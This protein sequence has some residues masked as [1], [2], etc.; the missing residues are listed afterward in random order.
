VE[1]L[2]RDVVPVESAGVGVL[3]RILAYL[4]MMLPPVAVPLALV[5]WLPVFRTAT[6]RVYLLG[7]GWL[8]LASVFSGLGA[9]GIFLWH[10]IP[11]LAGASR[12]F[13]PVEFISPAWGLWL[14]LGS[15]LVIWVS[16][17]V[18]WRLLPS[19]LIGAPEPGAT[20]VYSRHGVV[21]TLVTGGVAL[22]TAGFLLL[23]WAQTQCSALVISLTHTASG[24]C[25]TLDGY[26]ALSYAFANAQPFG[27]FLDPNTISPAHVLAQPW[28]IVL[29]CGALAI[30][31]LWWQPRTIATHVCSA[32]WLAGAIILT[33][34]G[35]YGV[36]NIF[37][38]A[39]TLIYGASAGWGTGAGVVVALVGIALTAFG[40]A[41]LAWRQARPADVRL[42]ASV[43]GDV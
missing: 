41:L 28:E 11:T 22:W 39:P 1:L 21:E 2:L 23:P 43:T 17:I 37:D 4:L 19:R 5:L 25:S 18:A 7:F 12:P 30:V 9:A 14:S 20:R 26:D 24:N 6:R 31:L 27:I 16:L 42:A 32:I 8:S 36:N 13:R 35:I 15:L 34:L 3:G 10:G 40:V 33:G 38:G 29:T